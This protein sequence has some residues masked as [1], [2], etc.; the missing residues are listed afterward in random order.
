MTLKLVGSTSGHTAIEAPASAGSNTLVLPPNNGSAGQVLSTDGNGNL[1]WITPYSA[2]AAR[3]FYGYKNNGSNQA[4]S[5]STHTKVTYD[6]V[7]QSHSAFSLAN[8][9]WTATADDAGAWFL[10]AQ[11]S[12]Y[13]AGNTGDH[14]FT[15]IYKNG[16]KVSGNYSWV[17]R[18]TDAAGHFTG[19]A[20]TIMPIASGD[21][22]E[23]YGYAQGGGQLYFFGGDSSGGPKQTSLIG[24]KIT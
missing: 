4:I 6:S 5:A 10:Q 12:F 21:Y 17:W 15:S 2:P 7:T 18:S 22:I 23:S 11:I 20:Q 13:D 9:K 8:D 16:S 3:Y 19:H 24:F 1:T 14:L